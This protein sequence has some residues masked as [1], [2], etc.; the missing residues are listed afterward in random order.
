M[1]G[2]PRPD[3]DAIK[4]FLKKK[5]EPVFP[6]VNTGKHLWMWHLTSR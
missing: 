2:M 3:D 5:F 6:K 1:D 4:F